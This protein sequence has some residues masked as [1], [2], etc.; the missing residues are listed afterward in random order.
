M[1]ASVSVQVSRTVG[2]AVYYMRIQRTRKRWG[3]RSTHIQ[4][5]IQ[6]AHLSETKED[7][8]RVAFYHSPAY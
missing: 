3:L 5:E 1:S 4:V 7:R 6:A 8:R 2:C